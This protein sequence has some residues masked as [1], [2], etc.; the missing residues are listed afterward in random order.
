MED[1][2][3]GLMFVKVGDYQQLLLL[4]PTGKGK[5]FVGVGRVF[6]PVVAVQVLIGPHQRGTVSSKVEYLRIVVAQRFFI[7]GELP[8]VKLP[9]IHPLLVL[10][11]AD[12]IKDGGAAGLAK[13][14][15]LCAWLTYFLTKVNHR[16]G[17]RACSRHH[18]SREGLP[19]IARKF[20]TGDA[21]LVVVFEEVKHVVLHIG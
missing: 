5:G 6:G 18:Q 17:S 2:I 11:N 20:W 21:L 13:A 10:G 7:I 9:S 15:H 1:G 3:H 8:S 14:G 12:V 19:W 4:V 16:W